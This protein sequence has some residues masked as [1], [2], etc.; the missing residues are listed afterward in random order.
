MKTMMEYLEMDGSIAI[1]IAFFNRFAMPAEASVY[2]E[3]G[4]G[5]VEGVYGW[6]DHK[7]GDWEISKNDKYTGFTV[8]PQSHEMGEV[9]PAR[10]YIENWVMDIKP[11]NW[12]HAKNLFNK[13]LKV[14]PKK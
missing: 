2:R 11:K 6:A 12:V 10:V 9:E 13:Y 1:L 8:Y 5:F 4:G 3:V 14:A 7:I